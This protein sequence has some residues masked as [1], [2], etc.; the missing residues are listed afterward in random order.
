MTLLGLAPAVGAVYQWLDETGATP[1]PATGETPSAK[2]AEIPKKSPDSKSRIGDR[3]NRA[4]CYRQR[5]HHRDARWR[6]RSVKPDA[7]RAL[8]AE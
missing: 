3:R 1:K 7:L 5:L 4:A 2:S 6:K 8:R